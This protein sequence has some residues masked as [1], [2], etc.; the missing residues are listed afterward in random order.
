M[1]VHIRGNDFSRQTRKKVRTEL[2]LARMV[3]F[4]SG[5]KPRSQFFVLLV[6]TSVL[7]AAAAES[8]LAIGLNAGRP[9]VRLNREPVAP[10]GGTRYRLM[11]EGS[12]DFQHWSSEGELLG[13]PDAAM[14][15]VVP[16]VAPQRF[17]RVRPQIEDTGEI[18]DGAEL[19]GYSRIFREELASAGFL[20]PAEFAARH[21]PG[22][23]YLA[24]ITFDPT[25][26]KYWDAFNADPAEVN[27]KLPPGSIDK[28]LYDFRLNAAELGMFKTNGFVV[29]E[30]LGSFSFADVFYRVFSDDFPVFI[31]ADSILH[32]WHFSYQ[33]LLEESEE[34]QLAPAL[35]QILS[36]MSVS[37]TAI[38]ATTRSGPLAESL[39]DADYFITVARSLLGGGQ[40]PSTFG[41]DERVAETLKLVSKLEYVPD[42]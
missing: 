19:F 23:K 8:R 20:T 30:R 27:A 3:P 6:L 11:V 5:V 15:F 1:N 42:P 9:E 32:A 22:D 31:S 39:K 16:G 4:L 18:P 37:A 12:G 38:P 40:Q 35:E 26:A 41:S 7:P 25:S 2:F 28:R 36:G 33:R 34:T 13:A 29:S 24:T 17:F 21:M 14:H 10:V